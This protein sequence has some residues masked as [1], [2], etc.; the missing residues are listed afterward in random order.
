MMGM[1][2]KSKMSNR[3]LIQRYREK[4]ID[5]V[6]RNRESVKINRRKKCLEDDLFKRKN[7]ARVRAQLDNDPSYKR[8]LLYTSD[9]ADE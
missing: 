1:L 8:C 4:N 3:Y 5:Y 7:L 2:D 6:E 9:A